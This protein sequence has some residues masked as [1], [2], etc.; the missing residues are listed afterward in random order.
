MSESLPTLITASK[1]LSDF[2]AE[3]SEIELPGSFKNAYQ[4]QC[5]GCN[6]FMPKFFEHCIVCGH[7]ILETSHLPFIDHQAV[8]DTYR[9]S[10]EMR[11]FVRQKNVSKLKRKAKKE[12]KNGSTIAQPSK[13]HEKRLEKLSLPKETIAAIQAVDKLD[14]ER[15]L[16]KMKVLKSIMLKA[17]TLELKNAK[18]IE[19]IL[20]RTITLKER[21]SRVKQLNL[22]G[23]LD[24]IESIQSL[25]SQT[26]LKI[27][28]SYPNITLGHDTD[29]PYRQTLH[30]DR[31]TSPSYLNDPREEG[32]G[33]KETK[34]WLWTNLLLRP[35]SREEDRPHHLG[36]HSKHAQKH[37]KLGVDKGAPPMFWGQAFNNNKDTEDD[38]E[39]NDAILDNNNYNNNNNNNEGFDSLNEVHNM[40][41]TVLPSIIEDDHLEHEDDHYNDHD[42]DRHYNLIHTTTPLT[43]HSDDTQFTSHASATRTDNLHIDLQVLHHM[44][45]ELATL[46]HEIIERNR[47]PMTIDGFTSNS[48]SI[49]HCRWCSRN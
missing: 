2:R 17:N 43:F 30:P 36:K 18:M 1:S 32:E 31:V 33:E 37:S 34:A 45:N 28:Q 39:D 21:R 4:M 27:T 40:E 44:S 38:S 22:K 7:T 24:E 11:S 15:R 20:Q 9:E 29:K 8:Y 3:S 19:Q 35:V 16:K 10:M 42:L 23:Y 25:Y 49:P 41:S 47:V 12:M 5:T 6:S 46:E 13:R 26:K 14:A 48:S